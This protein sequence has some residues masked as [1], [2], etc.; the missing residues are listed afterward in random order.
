MDTSPTWSQYYHLASHQYR[1]RKEING[2]T[3]ASP[4]QSLLNRSLT[5]NSPSPFLLFL[6]S[7]PNLCIT[8]LSFWPFQLLIANNLSAL[9]LS[10]F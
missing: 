4:F 7:F 2:S 10:T 5:T 3:H 6:I 8:S 1:R 9:F